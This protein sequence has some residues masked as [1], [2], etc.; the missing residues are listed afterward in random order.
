MN[1]IDNQTLYHEHIAN[2]ESIV[3]PEHIAY[4]EQPLLASKPSTNPFAE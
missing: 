3:N 2:P 4:S 1:D